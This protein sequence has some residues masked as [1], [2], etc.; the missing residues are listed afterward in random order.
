MFHSIKLCIV[1]YS[2]EAMPYQMPIAYNSY[3][4]TLN[5][6]WQLKISP[7]IA[8][9]P[10]GPKLTLLTMYWPSQSH[11]LW[12]L[13]ALFH[14]SHPTPFSFSKPPSS[15]CL[16]ALHMMFS[17]PGILFSFSVEGSFFFPFDFSFQRD[18]LWPYLISLS[19]WNL[20]LSQNLTQ[21]DFFFNSYVFLP[22]LTTHL[23]TTKCL[24]HHSLL[25]V[26]IIN[27]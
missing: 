22:Y 15:F 3:P 13:T 4:P 10:W 25:A 19:H 26:P 8:K 14:L 1:G 2:G 21:F 23:L 18:P 20:F 24:T 11:P 12:P 9:W 7:D 5:Q 6:L 16:S 17:L 27:V